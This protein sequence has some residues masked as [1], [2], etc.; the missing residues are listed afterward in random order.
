MINNSEEFFDNFLYL[1]VDYFSKNN[2]GFHI[3][4][5]NV[6]SNINKNSSSYDRFDNFN[7]FLNLIEN[8]LPKFTHEEL[9]NL[10]SNNFLSKDNKNVETDV[11]INLV[12][13]LNGLISQILL[14]HP[15]KNEYIDR[16]KESISKYE[17]YVYKKN[18]NKSKKIK[19]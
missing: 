11:I 16:I 9:C 18:N 6:F 3:V 14:N 15:E 7:N 8:I 5:D 17:E 10:L 19:L 2:N 1:N 4:Y 13:E 12:D